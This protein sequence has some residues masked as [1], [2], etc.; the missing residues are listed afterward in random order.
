M[1]ATQRARQLANLLNLSTPAG[2]LVARMGGAVPRRSRSGLVIAH[3]YRLAVPPAPAFTLGNVVV[4]RAA[5][6]PGRDPVGS[7]PVPL[8]AHEERHAT[9]YALFGGVLMPVAYMAAAGWSWWRTGDFGSANPFER[10]AGLADGGYRVRPVRP[11]RQA[12]AELRGL[13][14]RRA[15]GGEPPA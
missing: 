7:I 11:A 2:L 15:P 13:V 1:R 5:L 8:L 4:L 12:R 14:A 10:A 9:Q 3:G 6:L